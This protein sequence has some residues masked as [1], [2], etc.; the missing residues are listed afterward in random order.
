MAK[1]KSKGKSNLGQRIGS[2]LILA[3]LGIQLV[4]LVVVTFQ[5]LTGLWPEAAG[6]IGWLLIAS[7]WHGLAILAFGTILLLVST[8]F[9]MR[10]LKRQRFDSFQ[11][12]KP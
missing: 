10:Q 6:A 5:Y 2:G 11:V 4:L 7:L 3:T 8:I 12:R 1:G 9:E